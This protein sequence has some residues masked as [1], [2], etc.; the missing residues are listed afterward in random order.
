MVTKAKPRDLPVNLS[1]MSMTSCTAPACEKSSWSSFSVVLNGRFPTYNLVAIESN[2]ENAARTPFPLIKF[3]IAA[4]LRRSDNGRTSELLFSPFGLIGKLV[5][6]G[7]QS[8]SRANQGRRC[9][10]LTI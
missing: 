2:L 6:F 5:G 1:C 4:E 3:K 10:D 9:R 7:N 8:K